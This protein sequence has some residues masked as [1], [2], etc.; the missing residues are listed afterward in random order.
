[1]TEKA[2]IAL[3]IAA[4]YGRSLYA[5][6][7]GLFCGRW[8]LMVLGEVN[9]GLYGLIGGLTAFVA[10]FNGVMAAGVTRFYSVSVGEER[11]DEGAGLRKVRE[12]FTAAVAV[13]TALPVLLVAIGY[14]AGVWT[15][16]N[17]L[18]I[19]AERMGDC[20]AVWRFCCISSFIGMIGVPFHAM[21]TAKQEIA[22]LTIYSVVSTTVNVGFLYY[23]LN[24]PGDWFVR[25][26]LWQ[27]AVA[28]LMALAISAR[29][30]F[31]YRECRFAA[32]GRAEFFAR[33]REMVSYSGWL[34]FINL[35]H[36][37]SQQGMGIL[38][39]RRFGARMNA[40]QNV[41]NTVAGQCSALSGNVF[42]AF[43]PAIMAAWGEGDVAKVRR[44]ARLVS[45]LMAVFVLLFSVPLALEMDEVLRLWLKNPPAYA[46]GLCIC[47][48]IY[49][50]LDH[51]S[52]GYVIA[53][54][55]TGKIRRYQ[56][57]IGGIIFLALP[58][59]WAVL[60]LGGGIYEMMASFLFLRLCVAVA[61]VF[62]VKRL[63]EGV[64]VRRW[65]G[66]VA[67]PLCAA[68]AVSGALGWTTRLWM[69]EG[70]G[71]ICMTTAITLLS[72]LAMA[73]GVVFEEEEKMALRRIVGALGSNGEQ[74]RNGLAGRLEAK[75]EARASRPES[76][77]EGS[78]A[79]VSPRT[80]QREG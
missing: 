80:G 42:G 2:R 23:A 15:I 72:T 27:A 28:S 49:A 40:A 37:L 50:F 3:N 29:A 52:A 62:L 36:M 20:I 35:A 65:V 55:A 24:H 31:K 61:R 67:L 32:M 33:L 64:S 75:G 10:F 14:P 60:R 8:A 43:S 54:N 58:L 59:A 73:W 26:A 19:P 71:R 25:W 53:A 38:V 68:L 63:V 47:A 12:W 69:E 34:V 56:I 46:G 74:A 21:Y 5:L 77:T 66:R 7:I 57:V 17:L 48:L 45:R 11:L 51:I 79:M 16:E 13:H 78:S 9:Y 1:M 39:N 6:A 22:E 41:G 70:F 76:G 18:S 44:G 30:V 4:T